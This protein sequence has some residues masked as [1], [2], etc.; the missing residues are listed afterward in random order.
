MEHD[1]RHLGVRVV[2]VELNDG[3][4]RSSEFGKSQK[5]RN[6]NRAKENA[7]FFGKCAF[8]ASLDGNGSADESG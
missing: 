4:A 3:A 8:G 7:H 5:Q 2:S 1:A 6:F